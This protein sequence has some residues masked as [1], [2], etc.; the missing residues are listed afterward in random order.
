MNV[1]RWLTILLALAFSF[2]LLACDDTSSNDKK[3][4]GGNNNPSIHGKMIQMNG[5]DSDPAGSAGSAVPNTDESYAG[6]GGTIDTY[7]YGTGG[8]KFLRSGWVDTDF[9]VPTYT[10]VV[11]LGDNGWE[12]DAST[13]VTVYAPGDDTTVVPGQVHQHRGDTSIYEWNGAT[14]DDITGIRVLGG[15]TLTLKPNYDWGDTICYDR[16]EV[17]VPNDMEIL[18]TVTV[19]NMTAGFQ[20]DTNQEQRHGANAIV[21]DAGS[22]DLTSNRFYLR[23]K[24]LLTTQGG[25]AVAAN[26]RG[27]DS[28]YIGVYGDGG[29]FLDGEINADAGDGNG[30]GVGGDAGVYASAT[31]D[32][33]VEVEPEGA[34]IAKGLIT[35]NGGAG[36]DGGEGADV[37]LLAD[38]HVWN[39]GDVIS[40]GGIGSLVGNGGDGGWIGIYSWYA[41]VFFRGSAE[42]IGGDGGLYGGGGGGVGFYTG[43]EDMYASQLVTEGTIDVSGGNGTDYG[44]GNAGD[45]D[46]YSYGGSIK[47]RTKITGNGGNGTLTNPYSGGDGSHIDFYL[48]YGYPYDYDSEPLQGDN[49]IIANDIIANGGDGFYAGDGG[50]L[51]IGNDYYDEGGDIA[52]NQTLKLIGFDIIEM[53]GGQNG[54]YGGDGGEIDAQGGDTM[55]G[56]TYLP[57]GAIISNIPVEINGGFGTDYGGDGGDFGLYCEGEVYDINSDVLSNSRVEMNGGDSDVYGGDGG[58]AYLFAFDQVT[59]NGNIFGNGGYGLDYGGEGADGYFEAS[60]KVVNN[61]EL[62]FNAGDGGNYGNDGGDAYFYAGEEVVNNGVIE[63]RGS[64][65]PDEGGDGGEFTSLAGKT[66]T[67]NH[68]KIDVRNGI[69]TLLVDDGEMGFIYFDWTDVT[70]LDGTLGF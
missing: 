2:S 11:D 6:D 48:A 4:G 28:G 33:Y 23:S 37:Y 67:R 1:K 39:T 53:N 24:G 58:Y 27:G 12:V 26:E 35:A 21:R 52:S 31:N 30:T 44:G 7:W 16:A 42:N 69:A 9:K 64:D 14:D 17:S 19:V 56:Y 10:D 3:G 63:L 65:G 57:V 38:A 34:A 49:I 32:G 60:R 45:V 50:Y 62:I 20:C 40:N 18:G 55:A 8:Q 22:F 47:C 61:A 54:Y 25:D 59:I 15:V 43:W 51:D 5:G 41:S 66:K 36:E 46:F 68:G 70:P 29:T 13:S